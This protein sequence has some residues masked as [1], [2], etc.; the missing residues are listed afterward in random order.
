MQI[1]RS[2]IFHETKSSSVWTGVVL[3]VGLWN[4]YRSPDVAS[5]QSERQ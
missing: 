5:I 4:R 3:S 1:K 2:M